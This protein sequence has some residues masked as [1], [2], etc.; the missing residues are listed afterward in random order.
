MQQAYEHLT[1][2]CSERSAIRQALIDSQ[3]SMLSAW[4]RPYSQPDVRKLV[5]IRVADTNSGH[6]DVPP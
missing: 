2:A 1:A 5:P 6:Y 3:A 4:S